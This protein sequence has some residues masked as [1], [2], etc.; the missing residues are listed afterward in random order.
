MYVS[1]VKLFQ[2]INRVG[3]SWFLYTFTNV[4]VLDTFTESAGLSYMPTL[5]HTQKFHHASSQSL[6]NLAPVEVMFS[7]VFP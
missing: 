4:L 3:T 5:C 1:L 7:A 2:I 6:Q